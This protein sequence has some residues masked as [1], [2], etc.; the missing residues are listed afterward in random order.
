MVGVGS[1]DGEY[2][3]DVLS[4]VLLYSAVRCECFVA[5]GYLS[6]FFSY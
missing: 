5:G 4:M 3:L 2:W 6:S 1:D